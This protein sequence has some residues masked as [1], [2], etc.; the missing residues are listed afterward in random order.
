[1]Y[2]RL[3]WLSE[4]SISTKW[5][6]K[7]LGCLDLDAEASQGLIFNISDLVFSFL[8]FVII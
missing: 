8:I 3:Q 4:D 2:H 5:F 6:S 7:Q 1:M